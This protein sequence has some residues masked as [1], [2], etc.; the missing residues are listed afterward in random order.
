MEQPI[1]DDW[2]VRNEQVFISRRKGYR[3]VLCFFLVL[4]LFFLVLTAFYWYL[5]VVF[6]VWSLAFIT[7]FLEWLKVKNHHLRIFEDKICLADRFGREKVYPV[8][9]RNCTLVLKGPTGRSGGIKLLFYDRNKKKICKYEDMINGWTV[10][11]ESAAWEQA[12]LAL[13]M[14]VVDQGFILKNQSPKLP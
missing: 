1:F 2:A 6:A 3:F 4:L 14:T 13:P 10:Y 7:I 5:I 11:G 8:E 12:V 9:C